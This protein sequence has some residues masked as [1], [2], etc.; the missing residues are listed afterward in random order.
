MSVVAIIGAGDLGGA[1]ASKLAERDRVR[2]V[3]LID[4]AAG[5][6]AGK[7]LDILQAGPVERSATR[8]AAS[9]DLAAAIGADVIVIADVVGP[10]VNELQG[11]AGLALLRRLRTP[12]SPTDDAPDGNA[13]SGSGSPDTAAMLANVAGD[14]HAPIVCAGASQ[15]WLVAHAVAE[16]NIAPGSLVG[17]APLALVSALRALI[18]LEL[19][20]SAQDVAITLAGLPP[21]R[22]A[23]AWH[24]ASVR[25]ERLEQVL[26][27]DAMRRIEARLRYLWPPGPYALAAAAARM[28]EALIAGSRRTLCGFVAH[29]AAAAAT[30]PGIAAG[31]AAPGYAAGQAS[32]G[33]DG[34]G[35]HDGMP[36]AAARPLRI[37]ASRGGSRW[38]VRALELPELTGP[39]RVTLD[40]IL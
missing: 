25:G 24:T 18:A 35:P 14:G 27:P 39:Q 20:G 7:A 8:L 22:L 15:A 30:S 13:S 1:L 16:L 40:A 12:P 23:V 33:G 29:A 36:R 32:A 3:R 21:D 19:N 4:Q 38:Q 31:H 11:E 34:R 5:V 2:E 17:S 6:A 10:P 9:G 37:E 28:V 26:P